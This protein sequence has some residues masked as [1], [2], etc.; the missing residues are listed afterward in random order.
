MQFGLKDCF[1]GGCEPSGG[2]FD[3]LLRQ[4]DTQVRNDAVVRTL[5][6]FEWTRAWK[7]RK[8]ADR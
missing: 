3:Q 6:R 2:S 5:G 4:L 8:H 1:E 7:Q